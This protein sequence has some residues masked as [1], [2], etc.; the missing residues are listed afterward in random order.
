M[1]VAIV[2]P[3]RL[4][5]TRLPEKLLLNE[6]GK[7]LLQHTYERALACG[8]DA[9]VIAADDERIADA[10]RAFGG[11]V[12]MTRADHTTGSARVAEAAAGL[13]H[14]IIVNL[15]G[16]EP[17]IDPAAIRKLI[18]THRENDVFAST[19]A[20]PFPANSNS[21]AASPSDPSA[22]KAI[23][24]E[25]L[26]SGARRAEY[27]SRRACPFAHV[28]DPARY[29]LHIGVYAFHRDTLA[30]FAAQ[31][32][33]A[34]EAAEN[35]EQLRILEMGETIAAAVIDKAAPGIDTQ[36]DY[37]AFVTRVRTS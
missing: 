12:V 6:T 31:P 2:I 30:E 8:A 5:S 14:D 17:E 11:E 24:G 29:Y 37:D 36:E 25:K 26:R 20:C 3:A 34:L 23:L 27:F 21:G 22:V 16:D 10:A 19:L 28:A 33:G 7:P 18:K 13:P 9:A 15:Q 1:S 32:R 4:G 35:L